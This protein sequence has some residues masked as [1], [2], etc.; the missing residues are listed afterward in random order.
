MHWHVVRYV[1]NA[2]VRRKHFACSFVHCASCRPNVAPLVFRS[3]LLVGH[4]PAYAAAAEVLKNANVYKLFIT[5]VANFAGTS[6]FSG[7]NNVVNIM[8]R[9]VSFAT[10]F[11]FTEQEIRDT[12][13]EYIK[14]T[15]GAERLDSVLQD[16]KEW[17]NGYQTH[18]EQPD[19]QKV[20][21]PW[22]VLNY[23]QSKTWIATGR[24]PS[25]RPAY[26]N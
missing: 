8:Q 6:L 22:S 14:T 13:A 3:C 10:L 26:R 15:F 1:R 19:D 21:N 23:F 7:F 24:K 18:P 2:A 25:C 4:C 17:Y 11:G 9:D 16:L 12:Y 20:Y 5:G